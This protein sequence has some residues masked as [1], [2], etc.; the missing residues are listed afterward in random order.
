MGK[1]LKFAGG[2]I[3]VALA[4]L[5]IFWFT[6]PYDVK[7]EELET[8]I[9]HQAYSHFA[10]V[11]QVRLHYQEKGS[12]PALVLIHGYGASTYDWKEVFD[13]LAGRFHVIAV[14][15][16][17]FGFSEKPAG[18]YTIQAQADL[19][20][21][22]LDQLGTQR[23]TLCGSSMGGAVALLCALDEPRRVERLIL[24]DS[25][26]FTRAGP[27]SGLV[28][29]ILL[30]PV[31]GPILGALALTSA[32]LVR[33]AL[34]RAFY[35]QSFVTPERLETHYRPL[36]TRSGQQAALTVARQWSPSAV[37]TNLHRIQPPTLI[38]WG[39][40]D[41]LI[42]LKYGQQLHREIKSSTL[43]VFPKCGHLPQ[44]ER[45]HQFVEEVNGF[46]Q[47]S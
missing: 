20:M 33:Q 25:A 1:V 16:K 44:V 18:D 28:P 15:L 31:I 22:L 12:G 7:L 21:G 43:V 36:R 45:P 2:L 26:A 17:G 10:R 35:D 8:P 23:A 5:T 32:D 34:T 29:P 37:E 4:L 38:L 41:E 39:A 11:D 6:R 24:V 3:V 27:Q 13:D 47:G 14:D 30:K 42:P 46:V 19:V 9:P 40:E